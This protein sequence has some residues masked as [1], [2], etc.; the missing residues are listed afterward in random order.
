MVEAGLGGVKGP[1]RQGA[2]LP[3]ILHL[4]SQKMRITGAF[5]RQR[6]QLC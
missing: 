6:L 2:F 4:H 1:A 5:P 3:R